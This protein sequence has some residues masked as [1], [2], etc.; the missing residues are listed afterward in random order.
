MRMKNLAPSLLTV[1]SFALPAVVLTGCNKNG[2]DDDDDLVGN[3]SIVGEYRG[4]PRS[5]AVC[6]VIG[7]KAYVGTG[8][9]D[10]PASYNNVFHAYNLNDG[11]WENVKDF[12]GDPRRSAASFVVNGKAYVVGGRSNTGNR[13]YN[14][15]YEYDPI[16]DAANGGTWKQL[17]EFKGA[18]RYDALGF[19][20]GNKGYIACGYNTSGLLDLW[21]FDP[22]KTDDPATTVD[23]RWTELRNLKGRKRSQSVVFVI[24]NKAYVISGYNNESALTDLQIFDP[25]TGLWDD[26]KNDIINASD[27]DFDDEYTSIARYN[28]VA[29][30]MNGKGYITTGKSGSLISDTWEYDPATDRWTKKTGFEGTG[31][32]GA[33]AFTWKNRGFVLTGRSG[34]APLDDMYE[35]KPFEEQDDYD[36]R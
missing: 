33:V 1:L 16:V 7:D 14:D 18:A 17:G 19:S 11:N 4:E 6:F 10:V 21:E 25:A 34:T 3:W 29:F 36:N 8:L 2:D 13:N 20:I 35:W 31:R 23:E 27:E 30:E 5:E 24:N 12:P 9:F 28:A 15:V 22:A 32:E 26:S